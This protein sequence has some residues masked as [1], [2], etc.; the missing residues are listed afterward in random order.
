ML[1]IER[2]SWWRRRYGVRD[3]RGSK[4]TWVAR[5]FKEEMTG[6]LDGQPYVFG[7]EGRRRFF[8]LRS[9]LLVAEGHSAKRGRWRVSADQLT[10][11]LRRRSRW[12][13]EMEL[14]GSGGP[15]GRIRRQRA[16]RAKVVCELPAELSPAVQTFV[17]LLVLTLWNRAAASSGAAGA[18]AAAASTS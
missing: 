2:L 16:R 15:V 10:Y 17:G 8:L 4:G 7:R 6:D 3:D 12:R 9:G 1:E 13:S 5:H 14:V 11:E 18:G